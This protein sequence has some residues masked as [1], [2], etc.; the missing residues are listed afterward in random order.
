M[1]VLGVVYS[2]LKDKLVSGIKL[3]AT[4]FVGSQNSNKGHF[5]YIRLITCFNKRFL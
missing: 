2:I 4:S 1:K 3:S 5:D